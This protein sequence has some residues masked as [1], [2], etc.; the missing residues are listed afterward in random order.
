MIRPAKMDDALILTK[1]S[2]ESKRVWGYP[3]EYFEIWK[4]E[5]TI[6]PDYIKKNEVFVF[7]T[8]EAIAGY[9]SIV[10]FCDSIEISGVKIDKGYWLEHM[11]IAP[12]HIGQGIGALL[13]DHARKRCEIGKIRKLGILAD[14][15]AKGFYGK[16]G[17]AYQ[18]EIPSTIA[19]RTTPLFFLVIW[20][21]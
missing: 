21:R 4:P 8:G 14:P 16:M 11:F 7:E 12:E 20:D 2:F 10:E 1:L 9:Y 5:L 13:F 3:E 17:C 18:G 6:T 15:H 19:G